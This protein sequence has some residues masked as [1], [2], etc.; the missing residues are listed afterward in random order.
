VRNFDRVGGLDE[1]DPYEF[2]E[3][4]QTLFPVKGV[5][6]AVHPGQ[7]IEYQVPDMFDRPWA[8][9]WEQYFEQGMKRP[10]QQ[11]DLFDFGRD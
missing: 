2:I 11:E 1:G 9:V 4:F 8:K 10:Q 6:T 5:A 7:V 3:C